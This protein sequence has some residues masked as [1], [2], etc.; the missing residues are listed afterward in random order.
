M[1][2]KLEHGAASGCS[3][4]SLRSSASAQSAAPYFDAALNAWVLSRY[5]DVL[6]AFRTTSLAPGKSNG[7]ASATH[8]S[9]AA[10][11]EMRSDTMQALS[12]SQISA[13]REF[14]AREADALVLSLAPG[15]PIDLLASYASPLCLRL[16]ATVTDISLEGAEE[17]SGIAR[18]VS[19]AA[20]DPES[21]ALKAEAERVNAALVARFASG[22][23][24]LRDST[25]VA[26]SQTVP[27]I[28][29]NAWY[30][31]INHPEEWGLLHLQP[32]LLDHAIEELLRYAGLVRILFRTATEDVNLNGAQIR[33]GD[34]LVLRIIEANRDPERFACPGQLDLTRQDGGH[35][36]LGAGFHACVGASLIRMAAQAITRPLLRRFASA[37]LARPVEWQGGSTF[38]FP[39][40]VWVR[41]SEELT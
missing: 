12:A 36:A 15:E 11:L 40:S 35:L 23:A 28:L 33:S 1:P 41:L 18:L 30:A 26:L 17:L 9:E 38:K 19:A 24:A 3:E 13:W 25:F 5:S 6:A 10:R 29:G 8:A 16:A 31:L 4:G 22:P 14:L 27:C 39:Q 7:S 37:R 2:E 34:V 20:A 32:A 21:A